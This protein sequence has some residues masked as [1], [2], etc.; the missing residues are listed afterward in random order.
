MK[1]QKE[2]R[3]QVCEVFWPITEFSLIRGGLK[4][5]KPQN[6][7]NAC[8]AHIKRQRRKKEL[9]DQAI[10]AESSKGEWD[11]N[12]M[13]VKAE[14]A[15]RSLSLL[16]AEI[17]NRRREIYIVSE[18]RENEEIKNFFK[19]SGNRLVEIKTDLLDYMLCTQD[20]KLKD[21]VIRLL[22]RVDE[23]MKLG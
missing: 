20:A 1:R 7:C 16:G 8:K 17:V 18:H 15:I 13:Q 9:L 4:H 23:S 22:Q 3:C 10:K 12:Q 19:E 5:G 14:K 21:R 6:I 11:A 2:K